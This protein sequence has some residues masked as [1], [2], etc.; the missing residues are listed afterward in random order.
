MVDT[1]VPS[2]ARYFLEMNDPDVVVKGI[3]IGDGWI[4]EHYQGPA[5]STFSIEKKLCNPL[6]GTTSKLSFTI[7]G[8]LSL[9]PFL[10][11]GQVNYYKFGV[12]TIVGLQQRFCQ[13]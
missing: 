13:Y 9:F 8:L 6:R 1:I 10:F 4:N 7:S 12:A 5:Y 2:A 11:Q 3:S